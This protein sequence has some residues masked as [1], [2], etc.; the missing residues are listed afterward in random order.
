MSKEKEK[1]QS[2]L[3]GLASNGS[4]FMNHEQMKV[5]GSDQIEGSCLGL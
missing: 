4:M 1:D 3:F 5:V 2:I